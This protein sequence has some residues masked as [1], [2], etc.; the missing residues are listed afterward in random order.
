MH[1]IPIFRHQGAA[2]RSFVG[3][4]AWPD[5]EQC[6]YIFYLCYPLK[7]NVRAGKYNSSLLLSGLNCVRSGLLPIP[8]PHRCMSW[9]LCHLKE[10]QQGGVSKPMATHILTINGNYLFMLS[11]ISRFANRLS[12]IGAFFV[13]QLNYK[14]TIVDRT[15]ISLQIHYPDLMSVD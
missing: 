10:R 6:I 12:H 9:W 1:R 5:S 15:S 2:T 7:T 11:H 13:N 4:S 14:L 8:F 3:L